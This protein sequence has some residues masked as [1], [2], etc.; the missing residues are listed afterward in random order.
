MIDAMTFLSFCTAAGFIVAGTDTT[1]DEY[2]G[3]AII[4]WLIGFA[5]IWR[6]L[7]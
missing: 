7:M 3:V 4:W 2:A 1:L 5:L 6:D